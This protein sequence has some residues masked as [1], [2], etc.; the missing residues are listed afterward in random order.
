MTSEVTQTRKGLHPLLVIGVGILI[1]AALLYWLLATGP[2]IEGQQ[3]R[4]VGDGPS[5]LAA[6]DQA[7]FSQLGKVGVEQLSVWEGE[8]KIALIPV[9]TRVQVLAVDAPRSRIRIL[10]TGKEYYVLTTSVGH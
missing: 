5:V 4:I 7:T 8:G 3:G 2:A 6:A 9:G 10:D 1:I